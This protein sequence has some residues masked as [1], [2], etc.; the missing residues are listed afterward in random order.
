MFEIKG[1]SWHLPVRASRPNCI[2]VLLSV[3]WGGKQRDLHAGFQFNGVNRGFV[4]SFYAGKYVVNQP[5][6]WLSETC[7]HRD[8]SF[9]MLSSV[10]LLL[11]V[12]LFCNFS[13]VCDAWSLYC[14]TDMW[15]P[16]SNSNQH[17][18][19]PTDIHG[20]VPELMGHIET[21]LCVNDRYHPP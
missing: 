14:T 9:Q 5:H 1:P 10:L 7:T 2:V 16:V 20:S 17:V 3:C 15:L 21:L 13:D 12:A 6:Q 4:P 8:T 19:W 11:N 18:T